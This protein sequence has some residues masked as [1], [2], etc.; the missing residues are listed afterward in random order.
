MAKI[1]L[2]GRLMDSS[3][4]RIDP[5]DRGMLLA[6]G[7]FETLRVY[8][9]RPFQ[10]DAHLTRLAAGASALGIPIPVT[11]TVAA[12]VAETLGANGH[13]EA[14]LRITLTRGPGLRG[15]LPPPDPSPTLLIVSHPLDG[16]SPN[17]MSA[18]VSTIRRNEHSPLSRLKSLAYLDNVLA[19]REAAAAGCDEAL[20][21]NTAGRLAGGSRSN[22]FLV[23]EGRLVTPPPSEGVLAG[24]ARQTIMD[25]AAACGMEVREDGLALAHID[26]ASEALICNSLLEVR[27]LSRI[28][29]RAFAPGTVGAE[30]ARRY[31]AITA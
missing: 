16:A 21:L 18:H 12:A 20:L 24:I 22:L 28:G 31:K 2:N 26:Q 1:H 13:A 27:P 10:L 6:D 4:A 7:L 23:L 19:L 30:L 15:L 11:G 29:S 8:G 14:S 3:A 25:L 5:S 17:P 9:G